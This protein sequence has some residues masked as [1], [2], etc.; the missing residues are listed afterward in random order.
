[1]GEVGVGKSRTITPTPP[2]TPPTVPLVE[3]CTCSKYIL[4]ITDVIVL[5]R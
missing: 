2:L 4:L 1:M 5:R 3:E